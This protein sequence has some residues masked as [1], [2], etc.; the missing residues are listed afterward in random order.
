MSCCSLTTSLS[1]AT[2]PVEAGKYKLAW[3]LLLE[4]VEI[5]KSPASTQ[6]A[7]QERDVSKLEED[8]SILSR[9][10]GLTETLSSP[11]QVSPVFTSPRHVKRMVNFLK[12]LD[13]IGNYSLLA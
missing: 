3:K 4:D 11:H 2:L 7:N 12:A 1:P 10:T 6:Q 9:I 5:V 8:L 13:T